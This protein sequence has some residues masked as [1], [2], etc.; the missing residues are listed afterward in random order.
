MT[1]SFHDL[2]PE[3]DEKAPARTALLLSGAV[4]VLDPQLIVLGGDMAQSPIYLSEIREQINNLCLS[5]TAKSLEYQSVNYSEK[6]LC[7]CAAMIGYN[8][9]IE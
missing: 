8:E 6:Q 5:E 9:Y 2:F 3:H 4:S 1:K 7:V